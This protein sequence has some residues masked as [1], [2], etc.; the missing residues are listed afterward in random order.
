MA[1][2]LKNKGESYIE[3]AEVGVEKLKSDINES[4]FDDTAYYWL[5]KGYEL[6]EDAEL[7]DEWKKKRDI[8]FENKNKVYDENTLLE[9]GLMGVDEL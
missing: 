8:Y 7:V 3:E 5:I 6:L 2:L 9:G 4:N 1:N